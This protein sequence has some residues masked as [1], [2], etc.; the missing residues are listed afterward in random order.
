MGMPRYIG[1]SFNDLMQRQQHV[2]N[3]RFHN[4]KLNEL[5][6]ANGPLQMEFHDPILRSEAACKAAKTWCSSKGAKVTNESCEPEGRS[7]VV[8]AAA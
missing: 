1:M 7:L 3:G 2:N 4:R 6:K 8:K 5:V